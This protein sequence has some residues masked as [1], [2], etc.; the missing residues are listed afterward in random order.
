MHSGDEQIDEH[1]LSDVVDENVSDAEDETLTVQE[2]RGRVPKPN[3]AAGSSAS[4]AAPS[5]EAAKGSSDEEDSSDESE[6]GDSSDSNS[7]GVAPSAAVQPAKRLCSSK[8]PSIAAGAPATPRRSNSPAL[9]LISARSTE[10]M[11]VEREAEA[12]SDDDNA[13]AQSILKEC[14]IFLKQWRAGAFESLRGLSLQMS[15]REW[16]AGMSAPGEKLL[17][18]DGNNQE[19]KDA[20]GQVMSVRELL[21]IKSKATCTWPEVDA[22]WKRMKSSNVEISQSTLRFLWD[23]NTTLC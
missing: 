7:S 2:L 9:S 8:T 23:K 19:L 12:D 14:L 18:K 5:A 20:L 17:I 3:V 10:K 16:E 22:V 21:T 6:D 4:T 11:V 15:Q 1:E 13:N